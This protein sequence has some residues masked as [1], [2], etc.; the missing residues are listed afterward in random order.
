MDEKK[1]KKFEQPN[2]D[3]IKFETEDVI[4]ASLGVGASPAGWDDDNPEYWSQK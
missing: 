4:V 3:I 2:A 1:K